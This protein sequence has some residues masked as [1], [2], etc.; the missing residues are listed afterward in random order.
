[1]GVSSLP[2]DRRAAGRGAAATRAS[3][4]RSW[5]AARCRGSAP[6]ARTLGEIAGARREARPCARP[7]S[8][9]VGPVAALRETLALA[10]AA[11]PLHGAGAWPSRG[12]ARR[13]AASRRGCASWAPRSSRR[14]RSGSSRGRSRPAA[15]GHRAHR[16][17]YA[18]VCLTSP[19]GV[20]LL[21]DASA[22]GGRDARALAGAT[23]AAI[24]P[25]TAAALARARHRAPTWCR[26]ASIAEA[27]V[28]ALRG[29]AGRGTARARRARRG[30]ARRPARRACASAGAE[31]DVV[32]L[33]ETV[34]E[35]LDRRR[36]VEALE[37]ADL[38]HLHLHLDRALLRARSASRV[39]GGARV[40]SIG[41]V[42]SATAASAGLT[43]DVEAERHDIDG[44]VD[45]AGRGRDAATGSA[46]VIVTL[47]DRLRPRRRV[48]RASATASSRASRPRRRRRHHPRDQPPRRAPGRARPSQ[49]AALHAAGRAHGG[50]RPPGG[51]RAA[52][53]AVRCRDGRV[54]VGPDNG[55]LCLAVG[56]LGGVVAGGRRD[57]LAATGSSRSRRPSTAATCSLP[58]PRSSRPGPSSR[59]PGPDRARRAR[60][61]L[62]L[63]GPG[64]RT[65]R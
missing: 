16:A 46:A 43:V 24:G 15:G 25:G 42:T 39:P 9:V 7:R 10:R 31:V 44:L 40:V 52:R 23:V 48:R 11:R 51:H 13:P 4:P 6:C 54:L 34:A 63:P 47:P 20:R 22:S 2:R 37:R 57:A 26:S 41:P 1:M 17:T 30:G 32:A 27:L 65:G 45:G 21:F 53:V 36:A 55:L 5:S 58:W 62:E 29:R 8:R 38:R 35:P 12:R 61:S 3:R 14:R 64:S 28:E 19:N 50:R 60:Q 56:A 33:Y 49:R 59:T 18:L